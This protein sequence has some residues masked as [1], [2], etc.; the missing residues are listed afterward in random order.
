[1]TRRTNREKGTA[2]VPLEA[3]VALVAITS[4]IAANFGEALWSRAL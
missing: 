4:V 2:A 3:A 1:M